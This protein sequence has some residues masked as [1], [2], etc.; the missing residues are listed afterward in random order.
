M[1]TSLIAGRY[2]P[3]DV[4]GQGAS[5]TVL[6]ALDVRLR[7]LV[8]LKLVHRGPGGL[9]PA[10][11]TAE[12]MAAARLSH[13]HV[14]TVH[15]AGDGR[16]FAWIAMDLVI[17]E[18]L[19]ALLA[20]DSRLPPAEAATLVL[21]LLEALGHAHARRVI[22][23]DVKPANILLAMDDAPGPGQVRLGDFGVARLGA[24]EAT[25]PGTLLG[26]P[27]WMAPEQVRGEAADH[28]ADLWA[29]GVVLYECLTG[30]RP[31]AGQM[32][33]LLNTILHDV[34]RAP[35]TLL[36]GLDPAWDGVLARALEKAP[37]ARFQGAAEMAAAVLAAAGTG[38]DDGPAPPRGLGLL[39]VRARMPASSR[40]AG[41]AA[42]VAILVGQRPLLSGRSLPKA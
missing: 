38:L 30:R 10:R 15:D 27:A 8:A 23:R 3:R 29:A 7:R 2:A 16:D 9:E 11:V 14:V 31:F 39:G 35:S 40:G 42:R 34:P 21:E 26:T 12:A 36:A 37:A 24:G 33:G 41:L 1:D 6:E 18:P 25:E 20:R 28:R 22:H 5:G 4:I 17:G 32:P 19:S 13:P